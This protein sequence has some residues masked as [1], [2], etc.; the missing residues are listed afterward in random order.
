LNSQ[1]ER[2]NYH[3]ARHADQAIPHKSRRDLKSGPETLNNA[4]GTVD[5][6]TGLIG[7]ARQAAHCV[8]LLSR[9]ACAY[10]GTRPYPRG[11]RH[12]CNT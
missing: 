4:E 2:S 8:R 7:G 9:P 10:S 3:L 6:S 11:N 5:T 12:S 1:P